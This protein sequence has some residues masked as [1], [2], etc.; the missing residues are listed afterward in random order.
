[1]PDIDLDRLDDLVARLEALGVDA[2]AVE[3]L[4]MPSPP[5]VAAGE[6]IESAWGNTVVDAIGWLNTRRGVTAVG[7]PSIP[8][9]TLQAVSWTTL[10]DAAWGAGPTLIAPGG[11]I[12]LYMIS[13]SVNGPAIS[14]G[15]AD[16]IVNINANKFMNYVPTGKSGITVNGLTA[17]APA[18]EI[19]VQV[20]NPN[21]G[22][23]FFNV[24]MN[25]YAVAP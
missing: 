17:L 7:A 14:T 4:A 21:G 11:T 23:G 8:A 12:G 13:C 20:Y 16:A 9:G 18:D 6:L 1:M 3:P 24:S 15:F 10:S 25:I 5:H 22:A 2:A 19:S